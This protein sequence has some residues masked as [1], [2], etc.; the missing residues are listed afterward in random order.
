MI[1]FFDQKPL[2]IK[3]LPA[4]SAQF[5]A[6]VNSICWVALV[7]HAIFL[8]LFTAL[9]ILP[10]ALLNVGSV[11]AYLIC[12]YLNN[13]SY[14]NIS[15]LLGAVEVLAHTAVAVPLL[16]WNSGFHYYIICLIPMVFFF[17]VFH[18]FRSKLGASSGLFILYGGL[19]L[20][21]RQI[22]PSIPIRQD[23][24]TLLYFLNILGMFLLFCFLSYY[25]VSST[26]IVE[27]ELR[28]ANE[29]LRWLATT[30][31]LTHLLNRR[32][33][34]EQIEREM[35]R[36]QRGGRP[37]SLILCDVDDFKLFNDRY[38]HECGDYVL[39][40]I[41]H[42]LSEM[43]RGQ[44]QIARWGGEEFLILLPETG[45]ESAELVANCVREQLC[46]RNF[47]YQQLQVCITMTFG[48]N[49]YTQGASASESIRGADHAML[50]G[51]EQGKNCVVTT[52]NHE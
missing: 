35:K 4:E 5:L 41:A 37:F 30:D 17:P 10:L 14:Q 15:Q 23:A 27:A 13:K 33:I 43:L 1:K 19:Y 45:L 8:A 48:V 11:S 51:K 2:Q 49:T 34:L 24:R 25:Y 6:V 47:Y 9:G 46:F 3:D 38:G 42:L 7:M 39:E 44:D 29:Q 31:P 16:G 20:L 12:I 21:T 28:R 50:N 26:R 52:Q 22:E 36:V 40:L 32:T 18:T